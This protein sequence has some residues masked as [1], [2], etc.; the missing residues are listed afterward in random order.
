MKDYKELIYK[1]RGAAARWE[2]EHPIVGVGQM[3]YCDA[4]R[5]AAGAIEQ[6]V[7]E[8]DNARRTLDQTLVR[9]NDETVRAERLEAEN[10]AKEQYI[11]ETISKVIRER[12]A[13][14]VVHGKW[15]DGECDDGGELWYC[16]RCNYPVK[17]IAGRPAFDY[18][19]HCG[20]KMTEKGAANDR[21]EEKS[22]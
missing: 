22:Q 13:A 8:H 7:K 14:P 11:A 9:L 10:R 5:D 6:L 21:G 15:F 19:P 3:R 12:D 17:T 2:E 4:L 1:I 16:S 20:V 18:C